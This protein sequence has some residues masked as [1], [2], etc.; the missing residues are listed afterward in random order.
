VTLVIILTWPL[1][2]GAWALLFIIAVRQDRLTKVVMYHERELAETR[3][4]H[5]T[6]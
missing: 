2:V 4:E 6:L 5:G 3:K 1:L